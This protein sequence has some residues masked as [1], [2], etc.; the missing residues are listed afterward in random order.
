MQFRVFTAGSEDLLA[1]LYSQ[2]AARWC[3]AALSWDYLFHSGA[4]HCD[5]TISPYGTTL[6][7]IVPLGDPLS[8]H[9]RP[10]NCTLRERSEPS[11]QLA[12]A[13]IAGA[14]LVVTA[15]LLATSIAFRMSVGGA[16]SVLLFSLIIAF[17][18]LRCARLLQICALL[19]NVCRVMLQSGL[20]SAA[21]PVCAGT[22][23]YHCITSMQSA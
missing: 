19:P 1:L 2:R 18:F 4:K 7:A 11:V 3:G 17:V 9:A 16:L 8:S 23:I 5:V 20:C 13:G 14:A 21:R 6:L 12:A 22:H 10:P 15:P